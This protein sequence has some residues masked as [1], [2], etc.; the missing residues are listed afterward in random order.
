MLPTK[1]ASSVIQNSSTG[2]ISRYFES[3][4][5]TS[6]DIFQH[7]YITDRNAVITMQ[8]EKNIYV[9]DTKHKNIQSYL[10]FDFLTINL[11]QE[12]Q[13]KG[14]YVVIVATTD[15]DLELPTISVDSVDNF[16]S[17]QNN[18]EIVNISIIPNIDIAVINSISKSEYND[19][20]KWYNTLSY[21][22]IKY[23]AENADIYMDIDDFTMS[24]VVSIWN[25]KKKTDKDENK[26]IKSVLDACDIAGIDT[27]TIPYREVVC[28]FIYELS[29]DDADYVT[30]HKS[31]DNPA[32]TDN[33]YVNKIETFNSHVYNDWYMSINYH[34]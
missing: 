30:F 34:A 6:L 24:E 32:I 31:L 27:I 9:Y 12:N 21:E 3:E 5:Y 7:F 25:I 19:I 33:L 8:R 29:T 28:S 20:V 16:I 23:R 14:R 15:T 22:E 1:K 17:Y 2:K 10:P 26:N 11:I 4:N 13:K 18:V